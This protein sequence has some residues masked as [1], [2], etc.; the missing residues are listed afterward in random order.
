[1]FL[2][3]KKKKQLNLLELAVLNS[4]A[5]NLPVESVDKFES[6]IASINL[7][8]RFSH[9]KDVNFSSMIKRKP[10]F[11][12]EF[13]ILTKA[14][15]VALG[16]V[17]FGISGSEEKFIAKAWLVNGFLFS[18][19]FNVSPLK[20]QNINDIELI[21][22]KINTGVLGEE[23]CK[24][25]NSTSVAIMPD[26]LKKLSESDDVTE[27]KP[28]LDGE[29]TRKGQERIDFKLPEDLLELYRNTNGF[30]IR[31]WTIL[32]LNEIREVILDFGNYYIIAEDDDG[33]FLLIKDYEVPQRFYEFFHDD[34]APT[35][36]DVS[37]ASILEKILAR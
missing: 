32:S 33:C 4:I 6:Q 25:V 36:V 12:P 15:E 27:L 11:D 7:C 18:L 16:I 3:N 20:Y 17:T 8:Q 10:F 29:A 22:I 2:F 13:E 35:S 24:E 1:M 5:K 23:N 21:S 37:L 26:W 28:A 34:I 19:T 14:P 30:R 9:G 31:N